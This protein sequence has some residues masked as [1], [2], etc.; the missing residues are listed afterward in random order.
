MTQNQSRWSHI[1]YSELCARWHRSGVFEELD[2]L[3]RFPS[4]HPVKKVQVE[5]FKNFLVITIISLY[6][7]VW[8]G[9]AYVLLLMVDIVRGEC[10]ARQGGWGQ[11]HLSGSHHA[12]THPCTKD[13]ASQLDH[14]CQV[15]DPQSVA[16]LLTSFL[17]MEGKMVWA[18]EP[19]A[20]LVPSE[21]PDAHTGENRVLI[22]QLLG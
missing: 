9:I 21:L 6:S 19:I 4:Q 8:Y 18:G 17:S 10:E 5:A 12:A 16:R 3:T 2:V 1:L 11:G 13:R 22:Q 20:K 15:I 7:P 14:W